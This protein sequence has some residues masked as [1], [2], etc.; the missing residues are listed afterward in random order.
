MVA[1]VITGKSV[2]G[3]VRYNEHKVEKGKARLLDMKGFAVKNLTI[4]GK[5]KMFTDLQN[6]NKR[7]K[8]NTVHISL[9]FSPKDSLDHVKIGNVVSDYM[10]GIGFGNQPYLVYQHLDAAHPHVHI[11]TTNI[12]RNGKRIET[13]NLGKI[14][15]EKARKEIEK[16]YELVRAE[17]QKKEKNYLLRPLEKAM[18]GKSETK[19]TISNIVKEVIWTYKFTSLPELN[20]VLGQFNVCAYRGEPESDMFRKK[21]LVYSVLDADGKRIGVPIKAS[22]ISSRPT[23]LSLENYFVKNKESRKAFREDVKETILTEIKHCGFREELTE[24]LRSKGIRPVFRINEE[25]RMYGV[26]FVDNVSRSVFNGS[27]LDKSLS[28]N[29]LT[30]RFSGENP[31][32]F[33]DSLYAK[34]VPDRDNFDKR[35]RQH[36]SEQGGVLSEFQPEDPTPYELRQKKKRKRRKPML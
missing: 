4:G 9:N 33:R 29:A 26:T 15:S 11:V 19:A 22:S 35:E 24:R 31:D 12:D 10:K 23:L 21:G 36:L 6:L 8:T 1:K 27:A 25:G 32:S 2:G 34:S 20:A 17:E 3:A 7:T 28:A 13:H 5:I 18:Y 16:R 30:A 14:K